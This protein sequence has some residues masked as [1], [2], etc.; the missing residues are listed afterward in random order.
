MASPV[1]SKAHT[2]KPF[3]EISLQ[4]LDS[5]LGEVKHHKRTVQKLMMAIGRETEHTFVYLVSFPTLRLL[6]IHILLYIPW[7]GF[8]LDCALGS[9]SDFGGASSRL[10]CC[11]WSGS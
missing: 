2:L 6:L 10:S 7:A 4:G 11:H 8:F 9:S 5:G 3:M 1:S